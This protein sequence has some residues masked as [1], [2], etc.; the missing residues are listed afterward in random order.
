MKTPTPR[1]ILEYFRLPNYWE[2]IS[3]P[4]ASAND[5]L[6]RI[7]EIE[8]E[9]PSKEGEHVTVYIED[10]EG[11]KLHVGL[12]GALW[13]ITHIRRVSEHE[14]EYQYALGDKKATGSVAF[15]FPEWTDVSRKRL[16]PRSKGEEAV[17]DWIDNGTLPR[18]IEWTYDLP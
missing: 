14:L 3:E 10:S 5:A 12:A 9:F 1:C 16:I 13:M 2:E 8:H 15:L 11:D 18:S 4:I 7:Q 17:R 6:T